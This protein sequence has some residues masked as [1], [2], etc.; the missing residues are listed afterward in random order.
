MNRRH[1]LPALLLILIVVAAVF[2]YR[3]HQS[4]RTQDSA[5]QNQQDNQQAENFFEV[6]EL[7]IK[8]K[9]DPALQAVQYQIKS[10]QNPD[11]SA[12]YFGSQAVA[13][14]ARAVGDTNGAKYCTDPGTL[15]AIARME[16]YPTNVDG[17]LPNNLIDM[18][19]F[20][21]YFSG[22]Q[23]ACT[24]MGEAGTFLNEQFEALRRSTQTIYTLDGQQGR[25]FEVGLIKGQTGYPKQGLTPTG[26]AVC[27]E[28]TLTHNIYCS[29]SFSGDISAPGASFYQMQ[30]PTGKYEVYSTTESDPRTPNGKRYYYLSNNTRGT[31]EVKNGQTLENITPTWQ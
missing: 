2:A 4:S 29:T 6:K 19:N 26:L 10:F 21:I 23:D 27:A 3:G 13:D 20:L 1:F 30:L 5:K 31:V 28:N 24:V 15:G 12:A 16:K 17:P 14:K 11:G 9:P 22:P 7:G 18:G 25:P 8:F